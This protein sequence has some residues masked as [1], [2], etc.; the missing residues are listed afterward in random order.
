M[1]CRFDSMDSLAKFMNS[2]S[3]F[4]DAFSEAQANNSLSA[5]IRIKKNAKKRSLI[6]K[7]LRVPIGKINFCSMFLRLSVLPRWRE[8]P[9]TAMRF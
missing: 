1:N 5:T 7:G 9:Q 6:P 2:N 4:I 8:R 3:P